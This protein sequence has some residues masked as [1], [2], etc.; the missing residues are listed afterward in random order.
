MAPLHHHFE[1]KGWHE[2]KVV[3]RFWIMAILCALLTLTTF[4]VR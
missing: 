3:T 4:K 1:L 2:S